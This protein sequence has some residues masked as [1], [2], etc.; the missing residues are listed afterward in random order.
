LITLRCFA[1]LLSYF[2]ATL[3]INNWAVVWNKRRD[4]IATAEFQIRLEAAARRFFFV[5]FAVLLF[6]LF[7]IDKRDFLEIFQKAAQTPLIS[8][9]LFGAAAGVILYVLGRLVTV[10]SRLFVASANNPYM[11][12]GTAREWTAIFFIG[13]V[14]EETWRALCLLNLE[15]VGVSVIGAVSL[16]AFM[17]SLSHLAGLPPRISFGGLVPES[18]IGVGLALTFVHTG[19]IVA[20]IVA[21]IV[22]F[23]ISF[24]RLRQRAKAHEVIT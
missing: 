6:F 22:Y 9:L 4:T 17:F 24:L 13:G 15:S 7:A 18:L 11:L 23:T 12:R 21:N 14:V 20:A 10:T 16:S 3:L 5:R 2:T 19:D 1:T 8:S